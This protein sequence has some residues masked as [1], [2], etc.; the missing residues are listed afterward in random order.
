MVRT[1]VRLE[2]L[3]TGWVRQDS[4]HDLE[5][6]LRQW[7]WLGTVKGVCCMVR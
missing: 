6:Q 4:V 2:G 3:G 1:D 7:R 5:F